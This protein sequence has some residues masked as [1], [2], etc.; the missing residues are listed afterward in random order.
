M[1]SRCYQTLP[2]VT[3]LTFYNSGENKYT[4]KTSQKIQ[5][6]YIECGL[7]SLR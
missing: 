1:K 5:L 4:D 7:Q 3:T 2:L 6:P